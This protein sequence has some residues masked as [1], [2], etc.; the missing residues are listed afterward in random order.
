MDSY[1]KVEEWMLVVQVERETRES[2]S[3]LGIVMHYGTVYRLRRAR[4]RGPWV[5]AGAAAQHLGLS[6]VPDG[7]I[8][9]TRKTQIESRAPK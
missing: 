9:A 8:R 1:M 4:Q 7:I 6:R 5:A 2:F 3:H